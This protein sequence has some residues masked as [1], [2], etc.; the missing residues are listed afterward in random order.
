M[1]RTLKA[2]VAITGIGMVTPLGNNPSEVLHGI[3]SGIT[4]ATSPTRFD[5][6]SFP[7]QF[8]A[9]I[10]L[11]IQDLTMR[12]RQAQSVKAPRLANGSVVG[13]GTATIWNPA[14]PPPLGMLRVSVSELPLTFEKMA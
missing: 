7:C 13:S 5:A 2:A 6:S 9:R 4:E 11:I 8:C 10:S 14:M 12:L 1:K 3:K